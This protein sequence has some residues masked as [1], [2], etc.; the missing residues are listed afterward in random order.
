MKIITGSLI[1]ILLILFITGCSGKGGARKNSVSGNDT[2]SVPDTGF[3][4]I[5]KY[6]S[7]T[8]LAKEITF[9]NGVKHGLMKTFYASGKVRQTFWY[10]NGLRQDSARWYFEEGQ[11]FRTTPY[12]ND[13]VDGIQKQY[14]RTGRLKAKIGYS[15]GLRTP[16]IEEFTPEG[17]IVG[18]YP[19]VVINTL[20]DYK[21]K[22]LY[23]ITLELSDKSTKVRFYRGDLSGG[24]F[25]TA[26]CEI[27]KTVNGK[28]NLDLRK[29][30]STTSNNIGTIA[31]ILTNFGNNLL[32]YKKIDL[33]Y[34]DLN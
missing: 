30:G 24:V 2:I 1:T 22:G 10:E 25:D 15:K 13:T 16:Y 34:N 26:H 20:D 4:G 21:S 3:T 23:R 29:K 28:G 14:Y 8:R 18:G 31:E 27:I 5:S 9:K 17:K 33:P 19:Q 11:L 6:L 32:V 7:G 12:K